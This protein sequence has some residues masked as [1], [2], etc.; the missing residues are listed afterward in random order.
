MDCLGIDWDYLNPDIY[1]VLINDFSL[2]SLDYQLEEYQRELDQ[3]LDV[4]P[5]KEF[6][7]KIIFIYMDIAATIIMQYTNRHL[8]M[9]LA[10]LVSA[11]YFTDYNNFNLYMCIIL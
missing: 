1:A 5:V 9:H 8:A 6:I 11:E 7:T 2:H 4:T 3:F 10:D